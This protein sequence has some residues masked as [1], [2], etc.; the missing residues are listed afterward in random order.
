MYSMLMDYTE[1]EKERRVLE[2][3]RGKEV[4]RSMLIYISGFP[5]SALSGVLM[6]I[7]DEVRDKC[8]NERRP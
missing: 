2:V 7:V 3:K 1:E 8:E 4:I 6:G 5:T